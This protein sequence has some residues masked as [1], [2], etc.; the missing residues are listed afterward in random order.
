MN[1]SE[2]DS[3]MEEEFQTDE[4][5]EEAFDAFISCMEEAESLSEY[6]TKVSVTDFERVQELITTYKTIKRLTGGQS[7]VKV[8][9]TLHEPFNG[10]GYVTVVGKHITFKRPDLFV[11]A[12]ELASNFE[13]YPKNKRHSGNEFHIS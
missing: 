5:I 4:E 8:T 9:S 7:G 3:E 13:V 11:K 12:I 2:F 10:M 1:K 6:Q